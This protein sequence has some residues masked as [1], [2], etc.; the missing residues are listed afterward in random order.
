VRHG[1]RH[2]RTLRL[3]LH[4]PMSSATVGERLGS[5]RLRTLRTLRWL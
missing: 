2:L 5:R 1:F 3:P 4:P